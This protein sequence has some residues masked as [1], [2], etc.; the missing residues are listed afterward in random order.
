MLV[1]KSLMEAD[2]FRVFMEM[3]LKLTRNAPGSDA[4]TRTMFESL[5]GLPQEPEILSMGC[6]QGNDVLELLRCSKGRATAVDMMK[7]LIA[8]LEVKAEAAGISGERLR[9]VCSDFEA[10]DLPEGIFDLLWSEGAIYTLGFEEGLN[11]W[12]KY[13]KPGGLAVVSEA[14]WLTDK[15]SAE[16]QLFWEKAYPIMGTLAENTKRAKRAGFELLETRLLPEEDWWTEYYQPLIP[17]IAEAREAHAGD[18]GVT[19]M[20]DEEETEIRLYE[21]H[22][23]EYGYVFYVLG[24]IG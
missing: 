10:L 5:E 17:L 11:A 1:G 16:A 2:P 12:A 9:T 14:T 7:P 24:K 23:T 20:L 15:P 8:K 22:A 21:R 18:A 6:G 13:L 19:A 4:T 3:Q